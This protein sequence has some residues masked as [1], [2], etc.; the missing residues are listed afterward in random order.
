M[1]WRFA[2]GPALLLSPVCSTAR[3]SPPARRTKL[4]A[5]RLIDTVRVLAADEMEGRGAG[6]QGIDAAAQYIAGQFDE[7]GLRT[8]VCDGTPFQ[9]FD[10]PRPA[11]TGSY[12]G[13]SADR[14]TDRLRATA[15]TRQVRTGQGF[16][17]VGGRWLGQ[18]PW[19][20]R[21]CRLR[22]HGAA[23]GNTTTMRAWT[24]RARSSSCCGKSRSRVTPRARFNGLQPSVHA[25]FRQKIENAREHGAAAVIMVNDAYEL[26]HAPQAAAESMAQAVDKLTA[27][28]DEFKQLT[29][30]VRTT[31][32]SR[33]KPSWRNWPRR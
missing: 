30:L 24:C 26:Q 16:Q 13:E 2:I 29:D 33:P 23:T 22:H 3:R 11:R 6:T 31:R 20:A 4:S 14:S 18:R 19:P 10:D 12:G 25:S 7:I 28:V 8:D 9:T 15:S 5:A 21:V 17:H 32:S 27:A 1:V